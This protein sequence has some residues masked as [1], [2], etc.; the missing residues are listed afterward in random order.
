MKTRSI[1]SGA[2][3]LV[4]SMMLAGTASAAFLGVTNGS[5]ENGP[6]PGGALTSLSAGS[7][8]L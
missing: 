6:Y 4:A 3:A 1:L 7:A 5:F 2:A 8:S